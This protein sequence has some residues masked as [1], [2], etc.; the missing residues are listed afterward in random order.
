M[1]ISFDLLQM[2]PED[3]HDPWDVFLLEDAIHLYQLAPSIRQKKRFIK[4]LWGWRCAYCGCKPEQLTIDHVIPRCKARIEKT[5]NLI[6]ACHLCQRMKGDRPLLQFAEEIGLEGLPW[7]RIVRWHWGKS[8]N[9]FK[10]LQEIQTNM[11][12]NK[13]RSFSLE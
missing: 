13:V 5:W 12:T 7:E 11:L 9:G 8:E 3:L 2:R 6:P 1:I 4:K 10:W